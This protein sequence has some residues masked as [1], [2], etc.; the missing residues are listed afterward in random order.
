MEETKRNIEQITE[1]ILSYKE[2][3]AERDRKADD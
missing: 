1:D 3:I 2:I